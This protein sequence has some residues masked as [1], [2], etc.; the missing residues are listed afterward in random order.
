VSTM[1]FV[2]RSMLLAWAAVLAMAARTAAPFSG[3]SAMVFE[4][5]PAGKRV[6]LPKFEENM[7]LMQTLHAGR[8]LA[9]DT[10]ARHGID[11]ALFY[12]RSERFYDRPVAEIPF[13]A[14]DGRATYF[15]ARGSRPALLLWRQ[16]LNGAWRFPPIVAPEGLAVLARYG[17]PTSQP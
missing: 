9:T 7:Q 10:A 5:G 4:V 6:M 3:P 14:A 17:V 13:A 12:A 2:A 8:V 15:P 1:R 11:V 16:S